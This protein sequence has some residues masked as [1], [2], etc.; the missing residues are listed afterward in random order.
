MNELLLGVSSSWD[1]VLISLIYSFLCLLAY[2]S[3]HLFI[4]LLFIY[5]NN[6]RTYGLIFHFL[7]ISLCACV[8]FVHVSTRLI[9]RHFLRYKFLFSTKIFASF[10][11]SSY[12]LSVFTVTLI[13]D[14]GTWSV[15]I[16]HHP[17]SFI[18]FFHPSTGRELKTWRSSGMVY[19]YLSVLWM[20]RLR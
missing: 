3:I 20:S 12:L 2:L 10:L 1:K 7:Y 16:N 4:Y 15:F 18:S 19:H 8:H 11:V 6:N 5:F 14:F 13:F 9:V 17:S